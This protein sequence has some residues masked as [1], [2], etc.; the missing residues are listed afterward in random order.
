VFLLVVHFVYVAVTDL[1]LHLEVRSDVVALLYV[2]NWFVA[3]G[4]PV[5]AGY[6]HLWSLSV[7]EQ[8]YA[9][10]PIVTIALLR[11]R[12]TRRFAVAIIGAA[13][14]AFVVWRAAAWNDGT[15]FFQIDRVYNRTQVHADALLVGA[16]AA[17]AWTQ[18]RLHRQA[19]NVAATIAVVF[20]AVC[21]CRLPDTT[22]FYYKGGFTL[23]AIAAAII[24]LA[25]VDGDWIVGRVLSWGP[26]R[27]IGRVSYGLYLWHFPVFV[28][29]L[30]YCN[31]WPRVKSIALAF[32]ITAA[33]TVVSWYL[34]ETPFLRQKARL[35]LE[36]T[37]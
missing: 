29:V 1:N 10:W 33:C 34:V 20:I 27:A 3:T 35:R 9:V 2:T 12:S 7:E 14:V 13:V 21:A 23:V 37:G 25:V 22:G 32:A 17:Y 16:L 18:R 4:H 31:A 11:F 15:N 26:L 24:V 30:R 6:R 8:F 36:P 5:A 19:L 28:A